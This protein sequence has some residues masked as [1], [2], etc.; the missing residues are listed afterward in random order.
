M[1]SNVIEFSL[2]TK[3][4]NT[5]LKQLERYKKDFNTKWTLLM[6]RLV[7][8]GAEIAKTK[9]VQL[10][11]VMF[12]DLLKSIEGFYDPRAGVG[13]IV[14]GSPHAVFVEYGTGAKGKGDPHPE[15]LPGWRYDVNDHGEEGWWY[16]GNWDGNW[17]W[18]VGMKSRP[19]M[20]ETS[21]ELPF[22]MD[23]IVKEV[24]R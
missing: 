8:E 15:P 4:I 23:K 3:S 24:F 10:D 19:F 1:A 14:A 16:L 22:L 11:A 18:T 12:G 2:D 5:A 13:V 21:K 6:N 7:E 17:H 20:W 9:V